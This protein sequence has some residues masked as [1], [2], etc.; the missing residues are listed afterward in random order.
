MILLF[1]FLVAA[2]ILAM[3]AA[4]LAASTWEASVKRLE[5]RSKIHEKADTHQ[6]GESR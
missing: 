1:S 3:A 6:K 4:F 2:C 5:E